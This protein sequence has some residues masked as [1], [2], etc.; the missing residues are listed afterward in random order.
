MNLYHKK[1]SGFVDEIS[2]HLDEQLLGAQKAGISYVC[3]RNINGK[4][5]CEYTP[6]EV[7]ENILPLLKKYNL[8]V[9]SLGSPIGKILV[10]D[11]KAFLNQMEKA[12]QL[13]RIAQI[14][15]CQFV[16]IFSFY[17]PKG[18]QPE[19]WK[20]TVLDKLSKF[21]EIFSQYGIVALHENEK[22]IYGDNAVRC[23][24]LFENLNSPYFKGIFDFANFVQCN[25]NPWDAYNLLK[26]YISYYHIKDALKA[27][28]E[29]VV[30]GKGDGEIKKILEDAFI[31]DYEGFLTLE[32][33]LVQFDG[34]SL[35]ERKS[36]DEIIKI[37]KA[38]D[39]LDAFLM[40]NEAFTDILQSINI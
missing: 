11:E 17:I 8:Q 10:N 36:A 24:D 4:N 27:N 40:Q 22:E 5:I 21:V 32:P 30:C 18:D 33:H 1:I 37:N 23:L 35:L 28:G 6:E 29:T 14:L 31:N 16:R 39:G 19:I 13:G 15:E 26:K 7:R 12:H 38:K 25:V 34:L 3:L 20:S 2:N 9:S